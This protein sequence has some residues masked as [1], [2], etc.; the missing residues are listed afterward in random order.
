MAVSFPSFSAAAEL[1]NFCYAKIRTRTVLAESPEKDEK[2]KARPI[3]LR[4]LP[5]TALPACLK[6]S[7]YPLLD[8][9]IYPVSPSIAYVRPRIEV[10]RVL[11]QAGTAGAANSRS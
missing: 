11:A 2:L 9:L 10:S 3:T 5:R 4:P 7:L 6:S 8:L 1:D